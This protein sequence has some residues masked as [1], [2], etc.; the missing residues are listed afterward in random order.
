[1][2]TEEFHNKEK[3]YKI[4]LEDDK[5]IKINA[6]HHRSTIISPTYRGVIN[7]FDTNTRPK[8]HLTL[9]D[10]SWRMEIFVGF[11][12]Y[13]VIIDYLIEDENKGEKNET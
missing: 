4:C 3:I 11:I 9:F 13:F 7:N 12:K 1:M 2:T 10:I 6:F 8:I 5:I